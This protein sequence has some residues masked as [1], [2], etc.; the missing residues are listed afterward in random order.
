MNKGKVLVKKGK[1]PPR[2]VGQKKHKEDRQEAET[3]AK[4]VVAVTWSYD[5][6]QMPGGSGGRLHAD[7]A[8]HRTK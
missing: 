6:W 8:E 3:K 4:A 2:G 1:D 5:S 7:Q